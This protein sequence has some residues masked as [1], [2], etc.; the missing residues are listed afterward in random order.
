MQL[1]VFIDCG[2]IERNESGKLCGFSLVRRLRN[3]S[4]Y[5]V[6][7]G[8][9]ATLWYVFFSLYAGVFGFL[10]YGDHIALILDAIFFPKIVQEP[11]MLSGCAAT[12]EKKGKLNSQ[13]D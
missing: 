8:T 2:F 11:L 7:R 3:K 10:L 5:L 12:L 1:I 13:Q 4:L 9:G 6:V